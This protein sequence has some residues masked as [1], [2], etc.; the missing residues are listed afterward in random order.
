MRIVLAEDAAL[1][2]EGLAGLLDRLGHDVVAQLNNADEVVEWFSPERTDLPDVFIT[3]VRMPPGMTDDGL[4]AALEVRHRHPGQAIMVL[5]QYV[6]PVYATKLLGQSGKESV[7]AGTGYLLKERVGQVRD[8]DAQLK[9]V[10]SGGVI[11][12][13]DVSRLITDAEGPTGIGSLTPREREVLELMAQGLSNAEI[14]DTL[15]LSR[16]AVAKNVAS[17]FRG[18][19]LQPD[20]DN[21]R[22]RAILEYL[23]STGPVI[24]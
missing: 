16:A 8:F 24:G 9:R 10:A 23:D 21:R 14:A 17:I 20:E 15:F 2:R 11:V 5:S 22:V 4:R 7:E 3:D 13:P 6:A 1:I 18:L 12:D 19:G